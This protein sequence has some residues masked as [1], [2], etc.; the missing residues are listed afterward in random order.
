MLFLV[1][2]DRRLVS[3]RFQFTHAKII[4]GVKSK[5]WRLLIKCP[6]T[7]SNNREIPLYLTIKCSDFMN[8]NFGKYEIMCTNEHNV[9]RRFT[10]TFEDLADN[11][12]VEFYTLDELSRNIYTYR[13][14]FNENNGRFFTVEY[15]LFTIQIVQRLQRPNVPKNIKRVVEPTIISL[16]G[17]GNIQSKGTGQR[18]KSSKDQREPS[19]M[20]TDVKRISSV[21]KTNDK[22]KSPEQYGVTREN[23]AATRGENH[24]SSLNPFSDETRVIKLLH[25]NNNT[26]I[27]K[28][29][30]F[31]LREIICFHL[32]FLGISKI[33]AH[34]IQ[35]IIH[36]FVFNHRMKRQCFQIFMKI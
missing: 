24:M 3:D 2:N 35:E 29:F 6:S 12:T 26:T 17:N 28:F 9:L 31:V 21:L 16:N 36:Q 25:R 15:L 11:Y 1:G 10:Q 19:P 18:L 33:M 20:K 30:V 5:K 4:E 7:S 14:D 8:P 32:L 13:H 27:F 22:T 23:T 34:P